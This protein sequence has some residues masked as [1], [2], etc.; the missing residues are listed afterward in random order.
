MLISFHST[1]DN[2]YPRVP[3]VSVTP[4]VINQDEF[5]VAE[6]RCVATGNPEP[7]VRWARLDDAELSHDVVERD[8]YLRF[9]SLRASD[10]GSY[11]CYAQNDAGDADQVI[12]I[13]VRSSRP[14]PPQPPSVETVSISPSQ[15]RG[16]P[17]EE[18]KLYCNS[19][20]QGRVTWSKAGSVELPSNAYATGNELVI[21]YTA[22]DDSGRYLCSVQFP[23]GVSRSSVADVSITARNDQ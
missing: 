4:N 5:S 19:Q 16:E 13:Y 21:R 6:L 8:G 9:N 12:Q 14:Q 20:P 1:T 7:V 10:E 17:G 3:Q 15:F 2:G 11:R 18:V 22:V 23:N